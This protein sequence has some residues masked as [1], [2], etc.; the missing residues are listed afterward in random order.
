M[1]TWEQE[2]A[3]F[4]MKFAETVDEDAKILA[5]KSIMP[6]TLFPGTIFRLTQL[7]REPTHGGHLVVLVLSS[8]PGMNTDVLPLIHDHKPVTA[9]LKLSVP[10]QVE[11]GRKVWTAPR[12]ACRHMLGSH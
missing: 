7:V 1:Q 12:L 2:V 9:T 4:E 6:Q 5:L 10:S 8:V 3:E 11:A